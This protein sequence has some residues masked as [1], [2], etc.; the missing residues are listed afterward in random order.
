MSLKK[1][2]LSGLSEVARLRQRSSIGNYL[3]EV[4][5]PKLNLGCQ[6]NILPG[7]LNVDICVFPG[8][9]YLNA[10]RR[11]PVADGVFTAILCE[12]MIEHVSKR[13][14]AFLLQEAF[15]TLAPGAPVRLITPSL[16][17]FARMALEPASREAEIYRSFLATREG[18]H[19][20]CDAVNSIFYGYGH[21][22]IYTVQELTMMLEAA[23]FE[24]ITVTRPGTPHE[25]L[26]RGTEGHP[27]LLGEEVNAIGAFALEAVKPAIGSVVPT[28]TMGALP[29]A[30]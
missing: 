24:Q 1:T 30:A 4:K 2:A 3:K 15:R 12:H 14:A 26:F 11:W 18:S 22:Y 6:R 8:A 17:S 19:T 21:R 5:Q 23:G 9:V 16:D 27:A 7:W 20:T 25:P 28:E 10:T 29:T 13:D